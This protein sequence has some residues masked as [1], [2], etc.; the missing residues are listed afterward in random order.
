MTFSIVAR[1]PET[2]AFGVATA[3]GGPAVGA[4]VPHTR[5]GF[6]AAAT[7]AM[8]NPYLAIDALER[9]GDQSADRALEGAL[10]R[11]DGRQRRQVV[12]VDKTGGVVGWTGHECTG[13]AGHVLD[14]GVGVAGNMLVGPAVLEAMIG[15]Y[16]SALGS[17]F[18]RALVAA[19]QA[20]EAAGGDSRGISSAALRVQGDQAYADID[21]RVDFSDNPLAALEDLLERTVAGPYAAFF[22]EVPRR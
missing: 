3:T 1:D 4:L 22:A 13:F 17:G 16:R 21:L 19:M 9:L 10:A 15:A 7:Q 14:A 2:G 11:D 18:A 8:T 6:G 5:Q 20:G 12:V